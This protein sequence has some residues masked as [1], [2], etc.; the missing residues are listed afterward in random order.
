MQDTTIVG[1]DISKELARL[2][3]VVEGFTYTHDDAAGAGTC[4]PRAKFEI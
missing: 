3:G 1:D 2:S 4:M